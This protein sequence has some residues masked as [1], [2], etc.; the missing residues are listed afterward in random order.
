MPTEV[1]E[2]TLK[3][4]SDQVK[5]AH[6]RL[7]RLDRQSRKNVSTND[8]LTR[9]FQRMTKGVGQLAAGYISFQAAFRATGA[10]VR[11]DQAMA[12][13]DNRLRFVTGSLEGARR[14]FEFISQ[15]A[16]FFGQ[17]I[18]TLAQQY[19]SLGAATK[20]TT[21]QGQETR[22]LFEGLSAA[23]A[24]LALST[25][26]MGGIF[27]AVTQII[28]KGVVSMEELRQQLG[29]RLT[30]SFLIAAN[31][32]GISRAELDKLI[33]TGQLASERF[34]PRFSRE[35]VNTFGD[36]LPEATDRTTNAI[37]RLNNAFFGLTTNNDTAFIESFKDILNDI[38][39]IIKDQGFQEATK[40]LLDLFGGFL[41]IGAAG[42]EGIGNFPGL[43]EKVSDLGQS[44]RLL[45]ML[46]NEQDPARRQAII[47]ELEKRLNQRTTAKA[48]AP[49]AEPFDLGVGEVPSGP[50]VF[51]KDELKLLE[52]VARVEESLLSETDAL[53]AAYNEQINIVQQA[54]EQ[55]LLARKDANAIILSLESKQSAELEKIERERAEKRLD[56]FRSFFGNFSTLARS[57]N[58]KLARIGK[59]AA[60]AEATVDTY[61]AANKALAAFPPPFNFIA[62]AGTLATG[63]ANVQAIRSQGF[64]AGGGIVP[65]SSF[66]GD[67]QLVNVNSGEMIL[68]RNQ[69]SK[70]FQMANGGG[71]RSK[72]VV[73]NYGVETNVEQ[74]TEDNG[75]QITILTNRIM[76]ATRTD[77]VQDFGSGG[78]IS[79]AAEGAYG[80]K[81]G[82]R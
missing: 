67:N 73:N 8:R 43:L 74:R 69:Q 75:E 46:K 79:R 30:G 48:P 1:A 29:E 39:E 65:G 36:D 62:M 11:A 56:H 44:D 20:G 45:E 32:M 51:N 41:K 17:D 31:A 54:E 70:L 66:S 78:P 80:L 71:G 50:R 61:K 55:K 18:R 16:D 81:R 23:G 57:E 6:S 10:I 35:L 22:L 14:E 27:K 21:L 58:Q 12:R 9:S 13:I 52:R 49:A 42:V 47:R 63:F 7:D 4:V 68:N 59:V 76:Q 77:I 38:T 33:S 25:D 26:D 64:F 82:G 40:N 19:A 60:I 15:R 34:I 24:Q 37:N 5:V 2:L 3:V 28:N 72:I 53:K